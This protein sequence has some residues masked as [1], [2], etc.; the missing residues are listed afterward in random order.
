MTWAATHEGVFVQLPNFTPVAF[1][2]S[3]SA[4]TKKTIVTAGNVNTGGPSKV[5][6]I[7]ATSTETANA[8]VAQLWITR[9][10]VS[11]LLTS[12]NIPVNSGFDG[13]AATVNLLSLCTGLPT[14]NDGQV[15]LLLLNGDTLQVS[16]TTQVASGKEVDITPVAADF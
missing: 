6:A 9:S 4:N 11:Y 15:Y 16:L 8:R 13:T 1:T 12:V 2:N 3:D 10:A 14:D 7:M 5:T